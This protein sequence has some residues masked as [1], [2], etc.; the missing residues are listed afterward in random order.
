MVVNLCKRWVQSFVPFELGHCWLMVSCCHL[1]IH[2]VR[3]STLD[4]VLTELVFCESSFCLFYFPFWFDSIFTFV[5]RTSV[6]ETCNYLLHWMV[7]SCS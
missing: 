2:G 4:T 5:L 7:I 6:A 3:I 1:W